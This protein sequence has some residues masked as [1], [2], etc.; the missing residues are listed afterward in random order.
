SAGAG[1]NELALQVEPESGSLQMTLL[2]ARGADSGTRS[3]AGLEYVRFPLARTADRTQVF[4]IGLRN[5]TGALKV[6]WCGWSGTHPTQ[7]AHY[8]SQPWGAGWRWDP[9]TDSMLASKQGEL[10][11]SAPSGVPLPLYLDLAA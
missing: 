10:V 4:R 8:V 7:R 2:D 9:D 1:D 5:S 11:L 6:Y 3:I